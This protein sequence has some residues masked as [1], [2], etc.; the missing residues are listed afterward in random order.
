M[1]IFFAMVL[2]ILFLP[3]FAVGFLC[4]LFEKSFCGGRARAD[5]LC[6]YLEKP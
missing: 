1:K 3:V 2:V 4:R 6:D 5:E